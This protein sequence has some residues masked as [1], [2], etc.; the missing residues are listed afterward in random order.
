[1]ST[2]IF[3]IKVQFN[4]QASKLNVNSSCVAAV[5]STM[6]H[7]I[8]PSPRRHEGARL[9]LCWWRQAP[10]RGETLCVCAASNNPAIAVD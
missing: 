5:P 8:L 4:L 10:W 9:Q 3:C 1:M 6:W 7:G 2:F